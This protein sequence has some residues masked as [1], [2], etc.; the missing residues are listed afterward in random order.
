MKSAYSNL[1]KGITYGFGIDNAKKFDTKLRFHRNL[2]LK[3]PQSLADKVS[4]LELHKEDPLTVKCTDKYAVRE[5]IKSKGLE[6]ILV[7]LVGGPWMSYDVIDFESLP[8]RFVIKATHGCKMNYL[9]SD[10]SKMDVEKCKAE[11]E[12]WL[13]TTYGTYSMEPHYNKIPHRI[14]AEKYLGALD[15]M[16]DYKFHCCN[17]IPQ[18][19]IVL[20]DRHASGD[21]AMEVTI[22][23]FD[24]DW[25]PIFEVVGANNEKAGTGNIPC[26][27]HFRE[28]KEIAKKLSEDFKFVRV[29]LYDMGEKVMFG[30]L[31]FSPAC[32]VFPYLSET[33]LYKMGKVLDIS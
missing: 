23:M 12:R 22:D 18:F 25:N 20:T 14:Y 15:Q 10:K 3:N 9:V 7:P 13:K 17:G 16:V 1:L 19:V 5:Y 6:D 2:N 8:N 31:T 11:V 33:F 27:A 24:M 4:Y 30:E 29:D 28:M 21:K 32:C 26:P